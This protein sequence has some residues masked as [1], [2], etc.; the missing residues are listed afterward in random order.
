MQT[1]THGSDLRLAPTLR[2]IVDQLKASPRLALAKISELGFSAVQLDAAIPGLR[3]RELDVTAR[4]DLAA[5]VKRS[6]LSIAGVDLFIPPDHYHD[7]AHL[8]RA[9]EALHAACRFAADLG[10]LPLT[11]NLPTATADRSLV[12]GLVAASD[13]LGTPLVICDP[14]PASE[15][16]EWLKPF[17]SPLVTFGV[18]PAACLMGR[19]DPVAKVQGLSSCL[20]QARLSDAVQGQGDSRC[21]L[22]QGDLDLLA[23]RVSVDL[24]EPAFGPLVLDLRSLA[25]PLSAATAGLKQWDSAVM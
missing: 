23:Y 9:A 13:S 21:P 18:D 4:R 12:E 2:P 17:A 15:L 14:Q 19:G 1:L 16:R 6:G 11:I 22:G 25:S 8:D 20:G 7:S 24:A 3:P 10:R 5:A